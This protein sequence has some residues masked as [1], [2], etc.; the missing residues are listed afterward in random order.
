MA[1]KD[2]IQLNDDFKYSVNIEYDYDNANKIN[3]YILTRDNVEVLKFYFNNINENKYRA[4]FLIGAYGKG[5]SNLLLVLLN[6]LTAYDKRYDAN[7][8]SF[9]ERLK[10]YDKDLYLQVKKFRASKKRLLP[11]IIN[12]NYDDLNRSFLHAIKSAIEKFDFRN[13][14]FDSYYDVAYRTILKWEQGNRNAKKILKECIDNSPKRMSLVNLKDGLRNYDSNA[15]KFFI[16]IYSCITNGEKFEPLI[17]SDIVKI[18][19]EVLHRIKEERKEYIGLYIVFDEFS[20]FLEQSKDENI[21]QDI[22][23]LQNLAEATSRSGNEEQI[24]LTCITHKPIIEY[25]KVF[26][27]DRINAFKTIEG[28][29]KSVYLN[30]NLLDSYEMISRSYRILDEKYIN[31]RL[32]EE[33]IKDI[34]EYCKNDGLFCKISNFDEVI[35]KGCYPI[36]PY[37]LYALINLIE[38]VGQN[39]RSIFNFITGDDIFSFKDYIAKKRDEKFELYPLDFLYDYFANQIKNDRSTRIVE[40][41]KKIESSLISINNNNEIP[42]DLKGLEKRIIKS[43]GIIYLC[44]EVEYFKPTKEVIQYSLNISKKSVRKLNEYEKAFND[45]IN[46]ALIRKQP[47]GNNIQ[48]SDKTT[49]LLINKAN[50]L[51]GLNNNFEID[52][53][54]NQTLNEEYELPRRYNDENYINRFFRYIYITKDRL[55]QLNSFDLYFKEKFQDG[56]IVNVVLLKKSD[57]KEVIQYLE[58]VKDNRVLFA[59]PNRVVDSELVNLCKLYKSYEQ[60]LTNKSY[61]DATLSFIKKDQEETKEII[62]DRVNLYFNCDN[63]KKVI[64]N[65]KEQDKDVSLNSIVS[66]A[67]EKSFKN[68]PIINYESI[69]MNQVNSTNRKSVEIVFKHIID[70]GVSDERITESGTSAV[71][72]I[73][74]AFKYYI[75]VDSGKNTKTNKIFEEFFY[76][77]GNGKQ[78]IKKLLDKLKTNYIFLRNGVLPLYLA[79]NLG[80][81]N[82]GN[83]VLYYKDLEIEFNSENIYKALVNENDY[84]ISILK[85][86]GDEDKYLDSLLSEFDLKTTKNTVADAKL[87]VAKMKKYFMS[88][89]NIARS[90]SLSNRIVNIKDDE[91]AFKNEVLRDNINSVDFVYE[92]ISEIFDIKNDYEK[93]LNRIIETK[94]TYDNYYSNCIE[95]IS[96]EIKEKLEFNKKSGLKTSFDSFVNENKEKIAVNIYKTKTKDLINFIINNSNYDDEYILNKLANIYTSM[97]ISDFRGSEVEKLFKGIVDSIEE[98]KNS[99]D[100]KGNKEIVRISV[101]TDTYEKGIKKDISKLGETLKN[102]LAESID[103]YGSSISNQEK[104]YILLK[105]IEDI[106]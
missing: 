4:N 76:D 87:L 59:I 21:I 50:E 102:V 93:V 22:T 61:D 104:V 85:S 26:G 74:K 100:K 9:I 88:L 33:N 28:R 69:N 8:M 98:V 101:G 81:R 16:D 48:F 95:L 45:L 52:S 62:T 57:E 80:Q 51:V 55:L 72:S 42:N 10:K 92:S 60:L 82:K 70:N 35:K 36:N 68:T 13:V 1:L 19:K 24:H 78:V 75:G 29:F 84:S 17:N 34:Y 6:L 105:L 27:E 14:I 73:Y 49:S 91:I 56:I 79:Y 39:E 54:L 38:Y 103:E 15:Y 32:R 12:S 46:A 31:N 89:P 23:F 64:Y 40:I 11:V 94:K 47:L 58:K 41:Y 96:R 53:F 66:T 7:V 106:I 43:L 3:S 5:K 77:C 99:E 86:N 63:Y 71:D 65:G 44:G 37:S 90:V 25:L 20:K 67:C 30:K 2:Y 97:N 18:Y 83:V